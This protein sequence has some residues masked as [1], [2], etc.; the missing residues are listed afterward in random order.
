MTR[1]DQRV[2]HKHAAHW[3]MN[4]N[5]A[6]E[7]L[8]LKDRALA[9]AAEGIT[10]ADALL[11]D[12]P[13]IYV[14]EGFSRLTG[15]SVE[16]TL[17]SNCRFLQ[18]PDTDPA[19]VREIREAIADERY[20]EVE[21]LNYRKDGT[22][23]W[24]HL[25]ITPI[26]DPYGK[27][28]HYVGI[29]SDV[30]RR[31]LAEDKLRSLNKSLRTANERM[32]QELRAAARIQR[33]LLPTQIPQIPG[34]DIGW[35]YL[36]SDELA[37]DILDVFEIDGSRIA[38]YVLDVSGHG[39]Q[40]AL[41]S[42][43]LSRWI[44]RAS[45]ELKQQPVAMLEHLNE[46]FQVDGDYSQFFTC[47]YGLLDL[48]SRTLSFASA[49]HPSP[50]LVRDDTTRELELPGFPVGIVPSPNYELQ[51]A[52]LREGDRV[53][54]YSDGAVEQPGA[55]GLQFGAARLMQELRTNHS[56]SLQTCVDL[57]A[58]AVLNSTANG[59]ADDDIS[60]LGIE[61]IGEEQ[62]SRY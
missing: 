26:H 19:S 27:T 52:E 22:T 9:S 6:D 2:E 35:T 20:C 44:S 59:K 13:L 29:Q 43:T 4:D 17:G 40:A 58:G 31:R 28:T 15:Y 48:A 37:G 24:N 49:G 3:S 41:L 54:I 53:F 14:N 39:V 7:H 16:E 47:C 34:A 11:P 42:T 8:L 33:E 21:L 18:G 30:T 56:A 57:S 50:I 60:M 36:P 10:I 32:Q 23:F 46:N 62:D 55:N 5:A 25:S 38:F 12:R 61:V 45:K 51:V 1:N